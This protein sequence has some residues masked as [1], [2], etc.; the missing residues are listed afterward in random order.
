MCLR[1]REIT[2]E[3]RKA[4]EERQRLE[5]DKAKVRSG[6]FA[7]QCLTYHEA[8]GRTKSRTSTS[9]GRSD[10]EDQPLTMLLCSTGLAGSGLP[11]CLSAPIFTAHH[12]CIPRHVSMRPRMSL[13]YSNFTITNHPMARKNF[14]RDT[15][16]EGGGLGNLI[17]PN[18]VV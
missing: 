6:S 1:R 14:G 12:N 5:E 3:R 7:P 18:S 10:K 15:R 8:D 4:A 13:Y 11:R 9:Q 17:G 2:V 16:K